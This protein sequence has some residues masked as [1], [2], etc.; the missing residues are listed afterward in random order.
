MNWKQEKEQN[1]MGKKPVSS[2][3]FS[4]LERLPRMHE[5][6]AS[7]SSIRSSNRSEKKYTK[8]DFCLLYFYLR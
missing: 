5:T 6:L 8:Y 1:K 7:V 3:G 4:S 2:W